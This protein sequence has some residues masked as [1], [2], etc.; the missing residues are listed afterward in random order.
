MVAYLPSDSAVIRHLSP[1]SLQTAELDLL[2]EME[3]HLHWLVWAKTSDGAKNRNP[4]EPVRFVW[5][6]D[7]SNKPD[8]MSWDETAS[9]LGWEAE[10]AKYFND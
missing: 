6:E 8:S 3:Y 10:M 2:R 4:P 9:F 1:E 7:T 5:E